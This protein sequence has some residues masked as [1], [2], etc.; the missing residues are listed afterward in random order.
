MSTAISA[1]SPVGT[2]PR[3]D[4]RSMAARPD[5]LRARTVFLVDA[6]Y[7]NSTEFLAE[8]ATWFREHQPSVATVTVHIDNIAE[9]APD[10]YERIAREGDVAICAVGLCSMCA[11][12]VTNHIARLE[13]DYQVPCVGVHDRAFARLVKSASQA[14]GMPNLRHVFL[15][16]PVRGRTA[17]EFREYIAGPNAATGRPFV[18]D[19]LAALTQ[20]LSA[21][22]ATAQTD[23][24]TRPALVEARSADALHD[25]FVANGWTDGL[26]V[27]LPTPERVAAML[28][29]TSRAPDEVVGRIRATKTRPFWTMTVEQVAI[30]AVM[31]GARPEELPTILAI[32]SSGYTARHSS[33]SSIGRMV[34]LNGPVR[35][36][37]GA[38]SGI[39]ALGPYSRVN[40][41]IGRA[42]GL[43]SQNLQG[44]SEPG[45]TFAGSMG[46]PFALT[47]LTFAENEEASPWEP[48][49]V[50]YGYDADQSTATIFGMVRSLMLVPAGILPTWREQARAAL[51]GLRPGA[52]ATL[53]LDPLAAQDLVA[54]EGFARKAD[55]LAWMVENGQIAAGRWRDRPRPNRYAS[56]A[57][58]GVEP[59]AGYFRAPA[60]ELIPLNT[61]E[62]VHVV[63]VGGGTLPC[64]GVADGLTNKAEY[65]HIYGTT[66]SIDEWR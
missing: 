39:G 63:V 66:V 32:F 37:I 7:D 15:P 11:P 9:P 16:S 54:R 41:A 38:N 31:A 23:D 44:G 14:T 1:L 42:Y 50:Q 36:E 55:L 18:A 8:L 25:L 40:S 48:L 45:V 19:L 34:V 62:D 6:G 53:L 43:G 51:S 60:D 10:V 58:E 33:T 47:N 30:N 13:S 64:W 5:T 61:L 24:G 22:E 65:N 27:I 2:A 4:G 46:N 52:G 21:D 20:P 26:P 56:L 59:W 35:H 29:G 3:I 57:D 12:A 49:H 28:T 17:G